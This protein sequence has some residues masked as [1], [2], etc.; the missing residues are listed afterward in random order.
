M[1]RVAGIL[2]PT[3]GAMLLSLSLPLA[4]T[5]YAIAFVLAG[6]ISLAGRET[7]GIALPDSIST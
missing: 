1:A 2:A 4:L 5:L 7:M 6:A 3:M